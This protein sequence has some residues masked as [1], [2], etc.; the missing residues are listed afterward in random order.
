V[1]SE[2]A[3]VPFHTFSPEVTPQPAEPTAEAPEDAGAP[4]RSG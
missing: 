2:D 1:N 3:E 4:E